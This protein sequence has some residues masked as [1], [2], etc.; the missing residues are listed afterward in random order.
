MVRIECS[1]DSNPKPLIISVLID[2]TSRRPLLNYFLSLFLLI[3]PNPRH[4]DIV[5]LVGR[6]NKIY[7]RPSYPRES[8][9]ITIKK[10]GFLSVHFLITLFSLDIHLYSK[11]STIFHWCSHLC[12]RFGFQPE[13]L[14]WR[15]RGCWQ[16][17]TV[18][19]LIIS[20]MRTQSQCRVLL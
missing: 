13:N 20:L 16:L 6:K 14:E 12:Q 11:W 5:F 15:T 17:P 18:G 8:Q 2:P 19:P 9:D 1:D 7:W 3:R 4:R 10:M